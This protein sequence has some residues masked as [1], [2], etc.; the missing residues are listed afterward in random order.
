[1]SKAPLVSFLIA[2]VQ[3]G[4]TTALHD[5]LADYADVALGEPKEVHF[6][7]DE[8]IDWRAPDYAAYHV[9]FPPA[10]GRP[11]GEATPIYLYWPNALERIVAYNAAMRLIVTLRDPVERAWSH[12]RMEYARGAERMPFAWCIRAGRHRQFDATPWGFHREFSYV[13]RG[14]YG[15]QLQRLFTLFP[16]EQVLVIRAEDLRGDPAPTLAAVRRFLGLGLAG[17]PRPA[18]RSIHVGQD[19]DY[20]SDLTPVDVELLRSL[21]ARD[22]A[23]L[24]E[25]LGWAYGKVESGNLSLDPLL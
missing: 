5:Y 11:C 21:Y 4:G 13:E 18:A 14:F 2:G 8:A 22:Q 10:D 15:E 16:R 23:R 17:A 9:H 3:K 1:M 6:F 12:W 19:I 24:K 25:L 20:G 7:D